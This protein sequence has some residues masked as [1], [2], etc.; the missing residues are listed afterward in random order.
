MCIIT[1]TRGTLIFLYRTTAL[2]AIPTDHPR[3][4]H[5]VQAARECLRISLD[6]STYYL[7]NVYIWTVVCHWVLLRSP[8]TP[9]VGVLYHV[10]ANPLTSQEDL[11]LLGNFVASL[12][13]AVELSE[14]VAKLH[15]LCSTFVEVTR[16]YVQ[17]KERQQLTSNNDMGGFDDQLLDVASLQDWYSGNVSMYDLLEQDFNELGEVGFGYQGDGIGHR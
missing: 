14:G 9:F 16:A 17:A 11:Q 13:P 8:L 1:A 7:D 5:A 3:R 2:C 4:F 15:Q 6:M 12:R 10:I